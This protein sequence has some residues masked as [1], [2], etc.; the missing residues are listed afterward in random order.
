MPRSDSTDQSRVTYSQ[1]KL[2]Q[3][4]LNCILRFKPKKTGQFKVQRKMRKTDSDV[5]E[6]IKLLGEYEF[7]ALLEFIQPTG[8]L[9]TPRAASGQVETRDDMPGRS[10]ENRSF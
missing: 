7:G 6:R 9:P 3:S 8:L 1:N 2:P 4:T 10:S 5:T